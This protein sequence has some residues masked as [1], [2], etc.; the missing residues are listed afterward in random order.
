MDIEHNHLRVIVNQDG[1]AI[2]DIKGGTIVTLN[3]T[4]A[5]VWQEL[6]RGEDLDTIVEALTRETG[7][8]IETVRVD[9]ADFIEAL[10]ARDL[11]PV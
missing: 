6:E 4:G 10:K 11:F 8:Q 9:V 1:A 3:G 7:E 5:Y 2:L